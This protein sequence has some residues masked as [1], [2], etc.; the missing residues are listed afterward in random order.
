MTF[1][2]SLSLII[3]CH[4]NPSNPKFLSSKGFITSPCLSET[5]VNFIW[6]VR[7]ANFL[8][9]S[10]QRGANLIN[11]T[12]K[13]KLHTASHIITLYNPCLPG[14]HTTFTTIKKESEVYTHILKILR[15]L[16][17][18]GLLQHNFKIACIFLLNAR[19]K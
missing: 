16:Y 18:S 4:Y 11:Y 6:D 8:K 12:S 17:Y 7:S 15:V 9:F 2:N 10:L 3:Q 5:F 13:W 14:L 19:I 1:I